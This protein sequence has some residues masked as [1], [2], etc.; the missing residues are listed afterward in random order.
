MEK[1][2]LSM[3]WL[4]VWHL[5]GFL[6]AILCTAHYAKSSNKHN[7]IHTWLLLTA[8]IILISI[9][10][11]IICIFFIHGFFVNNTRTDPLKENQTPPTTPDKVPQLIYVIPC[12][13][14]DECCA[15]CWEIIETPHSNIE[16]GTATEAEDRKNQNVKTID[17]L[18]K[19]PDPL[20]Y[21]LTIC[22]HQFH[23]GC[24]AQWLR[25][26]STCPTCRAEITVENCQVFKNPEALTQNT[27][28]EKT[29]KP[30]THITSHGDNPRD[31]II[32]VET[33]RNIY[34]NDRRRSSASSF[35]MPHYFMH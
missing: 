27:T 33:T 35:S 34:Y 21:C 18:Q 1:L 29:K 8:C 24:V 11:V 19:V 28:K 7:H 31:V 13:L 16:R 26:H 9:W 14:K 15:V 30:K 3:F 12:D 2:F 10:P 4:F 6:S 5:C 32:Q 17:N 22:K 20:D 23:F 25:F